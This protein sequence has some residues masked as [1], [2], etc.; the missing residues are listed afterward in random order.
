MTTQHPEL[1]ASYWTLAGDVVPLGP[2]ELEASRIDFKTRVAAAAHAGFCGI[3][4]MLSDL[5]RIRTQYD[6]ATIRTILADHGM[7]HLEFEFLVGWL[8]DGA[9][10]ALAQQTLDELLD[11]AA[12][13]GARHIKIGPDMQA[14]AWPLAQMIE[15]FSGVCAQAQRAGTAVALE[16]MPWSNLRTVQEGLAVIAGADA[17]NGGLLL[18]VWH[19][20]RA[21]EPYSEIANIPARHLRHIEIDD[22]DA[23]LVGTLLEDTLDRRRLCG[24]GAL[25]VAGFIQAVQSTGYTGPYGVEIISIEHRQRPLEE[26]ARRAFDTAM[27]QF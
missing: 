10:G 3:G 14:K 21:G 25:N 1:I 11:A 17:P 7:R 15:R 26:A 19:L 18:D 4:L 13:L 12:Q 23:Q 22:A 8:E 24:E 5:Q 9:A 2:P 20:A 6:Y 27:A 16:I